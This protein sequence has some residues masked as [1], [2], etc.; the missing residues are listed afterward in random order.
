MRR[1]QSETINPQTE[2]R[3][4]TQELNKKRSKRQEK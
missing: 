1:H 3:T 4:Q 2:K